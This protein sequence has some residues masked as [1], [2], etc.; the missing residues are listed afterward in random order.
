MN[1][2]IL[3]GRLVRDAEC[4]YSRSG[5]D[6]CVCRITVAVNKNVKKG[7]AESAEFINCVAFGKR[8]EAIGKYFKKG[9]RIALQG[10]IHVEK[11]TDKDGRVAYGTDVVIDDFEFV[12]SIANKDEKK[13][14]GES[15]QTA[16]K[17]SYYDLYTAD[18]DIPF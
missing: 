10:R 4:R 16:Q 1:K 18:D 9:N 17:N 8:A 5:E 12:E 11:Y 7:D 14:E 6:L 2:V 15:K 13:S 3:I